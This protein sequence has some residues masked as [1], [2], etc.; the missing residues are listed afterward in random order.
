[1]KLTGYI[2]LQLIT[3]LII[4]IWLKAI[5]FNIEDNLDKYTNY[6][7]IAYG[8]GLFIS[9]LAFITNGF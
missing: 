1:M 2:S 5:T 4:N 6:G 7:Y 9:L 3:A 8:I